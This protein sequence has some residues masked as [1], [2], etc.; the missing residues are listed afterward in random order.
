MSELKLNTVEEM[1]KMSQ[2]DRSAL[3]LELEKD[4]G[5][6]VMDIR[7]GKEKQ[8]HKKKALRKQIARL[9]TMNQK[10]STNN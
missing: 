5:H 4:L 6:T 10:D 9:K 8:T 7:T 1:Q 2:K 3:L